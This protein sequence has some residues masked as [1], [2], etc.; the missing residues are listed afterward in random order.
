MVADAINLKPASG[1][2]GSRFEGRE[3]SCETDRRRRRV[4][5]Y[6]RQCDGANEG[7]PGALTEEMKRTITCGGNAIA[8]LFLYILL[9]AALI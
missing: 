8:D 1:E 7:A 3:Q 4:C 9:Y 6:R 2:R 5:K